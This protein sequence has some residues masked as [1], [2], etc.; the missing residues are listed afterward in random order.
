M[1]SNNVM[2]ADRLLRMVHLRSK[3]TKLNSRLDVVE[4]ELIRHM[5]LELP[6]AEMIH[7]LIGERE[8]MK[9]KLK[10]I[11]STLYGQST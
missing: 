7:C 10:D 11:H 4:E 3:M 9:Y 6:N 1:L 2:R 5:R 8:N